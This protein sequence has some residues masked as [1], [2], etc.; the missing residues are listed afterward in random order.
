M[1]EIGEKEIKR[2]VNLFV[3]GFNYKEIGFKLNRDPRTISKIIKNN[4]VKQN[5]TI[6]RCKYNVDE[7]FFKSESAES[8][9][10]VGLLAA[11]GNIK[12]DRFISLGQ[13]GDEGKGITLE[14]KRLL[15]YD[16]PIYE[17]GTVGRD[18]HRISI[19]SR[20]M[21]KDLSI[22][23]V[24]PKKSLIYE[25]PPLAADSFRDYLRGYIDGDGSVGV[26]DNGNGY[27]YLVISF[28]GTKKFI[29]DVIKQIPSENSGV[30]D[31]KRGE[32]CWEVRWYGRQAIELG[33]WLYSNKDLYKS[34]KFLIFDEYM[35]NHKPNFMVYE[36]KKEEVRRLLTNGK[37]VME[38]SK[39]TG[40]PF[41]TIYTW[42]K[43]F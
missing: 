1:K 19:T 11:D 40:I 4:G 32:N 7:S 6:R 22:Y 25:L 30:R 33:R 34:K 42:R 28:V 29:N 26:Y 37:K 12:K 21:V 36:E 24:I 8:M 10:L 23:N 15:G 9:W 13:S 2:V 3:E 16:G 5:K 39:I 14:V 43:K 31:L 27:E 41:Q 17:I 18:S 20:E 35:K 38:V